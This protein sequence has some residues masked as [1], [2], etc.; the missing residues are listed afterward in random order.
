MSTL[1]RLPHIR[2]MLILVACLYFSLLTGCATNANRVAHDPLE[3]FNRGVYKFNGAVD[4]VFIQPVTTAYKTVTPRIAKKGVRNFFGN[5]SDAWSTV[6][7]ILQFKGKQ[8][9]ASFFR[10]VVNTLFGLGGII[11][12]ATEAQIPKSKQDFG[13]TL[14]RWGVPAGPY[15]VLPIVGPSTV[16]DTIALPVDMKGNPLGAITHNAT[17][18]SLVGLNLI[19]KRAE[20]DDAAKLL[21]Q[22]GMDPYIFMRDAYLKQRGVEIASGDTSD[23]TDGGYIP[24]LDDEEALDDAALE[25]ADAIADNLIHEASKNPVSSN[26][27][28]SAHPNTHP[29]ADASA[30]AAASTAVEP[31]IETKAPQSN[32]SPWYA[33]HIPNT[34][35]HIQPGWGNNFWKP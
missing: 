6:N 30:T 33:P 1:Y 17:R 9:G 10:V 13:L 14:R 19:S 12:V 22:S 18:N 21:K 7:S 3:P 28:L 35:N 26:Q 32:I 2:L 16:R 31:D 8:A 24:P 34:L 25:E 27:Q 15:V 23:V 5:V 11:D 29:N 20:I 4:A